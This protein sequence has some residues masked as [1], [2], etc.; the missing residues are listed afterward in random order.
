MFRWFVSILGVL[1]TNT[2][3]RI[4]V[5]NTLLGDQLTQFLRANANNMTLTF[6]LA[7]TLFS[8]HPEILLPPFW[9]TRIL[10]KDHQNR[11]MAVPDQQNPVCLPTVYSV[12]SR[13]HDIF[14]FES[15]ILLLLS[16]RSICIQ[17]NVF[18]ESQKTQTRL[19]LHM[20]FILCILLLK[21]THYVSRAVV[22]MIHFDKPF[23][24]P[25]LFYARV[26]DIL[27]ILSFC[28]RELVIVS[29]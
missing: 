2:L 9:S 4:N 22:K 19:F 12:I 23:L 16:F 10:S 5:N 6:C 29:R 27:M 20:V 24:K 26:Y 28:F 21:T 18:S 11:K 14:S 7:Q 25:K 15:I 13:N 1:Y 17:Y 8:Y 3:R